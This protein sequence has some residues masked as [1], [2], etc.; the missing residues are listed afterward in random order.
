M[1]YIKDSG[2]VYKIGYSHFNGYIIYRRVCINAV[3][4]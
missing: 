1:S 2:M 4:K 3:N